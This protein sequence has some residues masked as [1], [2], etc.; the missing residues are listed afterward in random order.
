M[1]HWI[2]SAH[3]ER[4]AWVIQQLVLGVGE[5]LVSQCLVDQLVDL[6]PVRLGDLG[7]A[8]LQ[9]AGEHCEF[10]PFIA[11]EVEVGQSATEDLE[12]LLLSDSEA[13][14]RHS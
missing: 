14:D 2:A 10:G 8:E 5:F 4:F 1:T 13:I 11:I 9:F 7:V 3:S 6:S 12:V